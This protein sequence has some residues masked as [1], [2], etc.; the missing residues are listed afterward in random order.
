MGIKIWL[1]LYRQELKVQQA[2]AKAQT[3]KWW[4]YN[5]NE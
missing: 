1:V 5:Q 4:I 2:Q 3:L